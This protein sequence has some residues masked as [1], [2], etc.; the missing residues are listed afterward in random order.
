[1][2]T[3]QR[4]S[5]SCMPRN[6][7]RGSATSRPPKDK[8]PVEFVLDLDYQSFSRVMADRFEAVNDTAIGKVLGLDR[9]AISKLR[10]RETIPSIAFIAA[11]RK[12]DLNDRLF[13]IPRHPD[14]VE[15]SEKA[16]QRLAER[17]EADKAQR[18]A[19]LAA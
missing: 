8:R 6:T 17:R 19:S 12:V 7:A 3:T 14:E 9:T 1:M 5:V 18:R 4:S 2:H 11:C 10:R 16:R 13:T 15:R